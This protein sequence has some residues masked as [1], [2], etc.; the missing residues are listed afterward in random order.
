MLLAELQ[1]IAGNFGE[2]CAGLLRRSESAILSTEM[3]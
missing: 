3:K 1:S 2:R